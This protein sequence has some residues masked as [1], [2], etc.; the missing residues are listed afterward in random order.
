MSLPYRA[1]A[2]DSSSLSPC[3]ALLG[4]HTHWAAQALLVAA[5]GHRGATRWALSPLSSLPS[6]FLCTGPGQVLGPLI[7]TLPLASLC[8]LPNLICL[9]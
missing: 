6:E 2:G 5:Q 3:W 1:L 4:L 8:A 9:P 7:L